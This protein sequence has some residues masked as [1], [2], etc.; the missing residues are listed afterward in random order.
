MSSPAPTT[1]L[2]IIV[3]FCLV[4]A[5]GSAIYQASHVGRD[6]DRFGLAHQLTIFFFFGLVAFALFF[7]E[8]R[9][10]QGLSKR[11]LN[12]ALGYVQSLGCFVL[13]L[14]GIL[15]IYYSHRAP[16]ERLDPAFP[17]SALA[18]IFVLGHVIFLSNVVWSYVHGE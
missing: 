17:D 5:G 12:S 13:L 4:G 1:V 2:R 10:V 8:Y 18:A 6:Y 11:E 9:L 14:C 16:L 3:N 15:A 7:A